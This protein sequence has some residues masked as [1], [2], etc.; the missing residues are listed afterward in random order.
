[1]ELD[2]HF[3][4]EDR[5]N[6]DTDIQ[7][8]TLFTRRSVKVKA[9][10]EEIPEVE[11]ATPS[12]REGAVKAAHNGDTITMVATPSIREVALPGAAV[13]E[14]AHNEET[15]NAMVATPSIREGALP[16]AAVRGT[17]QNEETRRSNR[18]LTPPIREGTAPADNSGETTSKVEKPKLHENTSY[19]TNQ[20]LKHSNV[21]EAAMLDSVDVKNTHYDNKYVQ[22][23]GFVLINTK[24]NLIFLVIAVLWVIL[25][26]VIP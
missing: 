10:D 26:K 20:I 24:V 17:A 2:G 16:G 7:K 14:T 11:I 3:E 25:F 22:N 4:S 15:S 18:V 9:K 12:I 23:Y 21:Q 5:R 1:M 6:V 13:R 8:L 19:Q